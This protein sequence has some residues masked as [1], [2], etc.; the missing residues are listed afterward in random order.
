MNEITLE[1]KKYVSSKRAAEMTGYAKD[2]VG[3]LCREGRVPARL[4]GR[5]WYVLEAAIHDHR[6]GTPS[7]SGE[8]A[9]VI[10]PK[11]EGVS[12]DSTW[13]E[14]RY[15]SE[16]MPSLPFINKL[17]AAPAATKIIPMDTEEA[18]IGIEDNLETMHNAW[19]SWFSRAPMAE[20]AEEEKP[21]EEQNYIHNEIPISIMRTTR[22]EEFEPEEIQSMEVSVPIHT[23]SRAAED[24]NMREE[25]ILSIRNTEEEPVAETLQ[26]F[27][28]K[29]ANHNQN[30]LHGRVLQAVF[31]SIAFFAM[32]IGI[33]GTGIISKSISSNMVLDTIA[34]VSYINNK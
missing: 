34:G 12:I 16:K 17:A 18:A 14:P 30:R 28:N 26:A 2:Y 32:L 5:S 6:F 13:S 15:E 4:I 11:D 21:I 20:E 10:T 3:Q 23:L 19:K 31:M 22:D 8:N 7:D 1:E 33:I 24:R 27:M 25:G 9:K 29:S